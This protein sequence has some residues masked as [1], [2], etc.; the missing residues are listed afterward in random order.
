MAGTAF[1][2]LATDQWRYD[3][4]DAGAISSP[5]A[6]GGISE[7]TIADT[8]VKAT[9]MGWLPSYPTFNKNPIEIVKAAKSQ[10]IDPKD[11]VV[12]ELKVHV[13]KMLSGIRTHQLE[14]W[15]YLYR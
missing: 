1:W 12:Q 7:M 14:N 13:Q 2:Y 6:E 5:L 4:F 3:A 9:K 11:Y 8:L 10:G 15:I